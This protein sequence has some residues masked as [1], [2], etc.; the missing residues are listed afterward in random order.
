MLSRSKKI[1]S[2]LLGVFGLVTAQPGFAHT[3]YLL[4]TNFAVTKDHV[5]LEAAM[6][7]EVFFVPEMAIR[8]NSF[9]MTDPDGAT[10]ELKGTAFK[11]LVVVEAPIG[12]DGTYRIATDVPGRATKMA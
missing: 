10:S 3:P 9:S 4:P 11:D 6:T 8:S 2:A 7:G 1:G 12:K 5:T